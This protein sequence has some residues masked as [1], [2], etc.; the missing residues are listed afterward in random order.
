MADSVREAAEQARTAIDV[1][2]DE[3]ELTPRREGTD[4]TLKPPSVPTVAD[5]DRTPGATLPTSRSSWWLWG[6]ANLEPPQESASSVVGPESETEPEP[7]PMEVDEP[8][9]DLPEVVIPEEPNKGSW[10]RT[11]WGEFPDEAAA[12]KQKSA[13]EAAQ[14]GKP[15][16]TETSLPPPS[17]SLSATSASTDSPAGS[18]FQPPL[19]AVPPQVQA[20]KPKGSWSLFGSVRGAK[21][22][23]PDSLSAPTPI[24]SSG[25]SSVKGGTT[26]SKAALSR[27][28]GVNSSLAPSAASI[29]S[30]ATTASSD[31]PSS[32]RFGP[33]HDGPPRPLTGS[34][35]PSTT[36]LRG[37]V[38]DEPPAENLV[39]PS[40]DDTFLRA[41]RSFPPKKTTLTKLASVAASYWFG[42]PPSPTME[43]RT[44]EGRLVHADPAEKLPK[45]LEVVEEPSRIG[46][47]R[48]VVCIGV[49]GWFPHP[50][51]KSV[52]GEP[53]GTSVKFASK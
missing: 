33:V 14:A 4:A 31:A 53:T 3:G 21:D 40:F 22:P 42:Q 27:S 11:L 12:R 41:P 8:V 6:G 26:V 10:L 29:R 17:P 39:L 19:S 15:P 24:P 50:R 36:S 2:E 28:P 52:L 25:P 18:G 49:H 45:A 30:Q 9:P 46:A 34:N 43:R 48:R 44:K 23:F 1:G 35:K 47:V 5:E 16:H 7:E 20:L 51:L 13:V 37:L 32:P 38:D